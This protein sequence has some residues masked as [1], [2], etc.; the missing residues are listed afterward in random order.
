MNKAIKIRKERFM[1]QYYFNP[2]VHKE[3]TQV[4]FN[5]T[6]Q[7]YEWI[8]ELKNTILGMTPS[9][10]TEA[11]VAYARANSEDFVKFC[12]D[13]LIE[14]YILRERKSGKFVTARLPEDAIS[15][16]REIKAKFP[17]RLSNRIICSLAI[18]Y[19]YKNKEDFLK[20]SIISTRDA[21]ER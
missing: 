3:R 19:A 5:P 21:L 7:A 20:R 9:A 15:F 11:A 8:I 12:L 4:A 2:S 13:N 18:C 1:T 14:A 17:A 16:V 10:T 6:A